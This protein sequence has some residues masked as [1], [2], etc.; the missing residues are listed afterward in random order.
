MKTFLFVDK[1]PALSGDMQYM[2]LD[3]KTTVNIDKS[4]IFLDD[5]EVDIL[6][7]SNKALGYGLRGLVNMPSSVVEI[8]KAALINDEKICKKSIVDVYLAFYLKEPQPWQ[9]SANVSHPEMSDMIFVFNPIL[10]E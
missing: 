1:N 6:I 2:S 4:H 10:R 7:K 3:K 9:L 5:M 8:I